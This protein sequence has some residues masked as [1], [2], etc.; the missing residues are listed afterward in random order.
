M[1]IIPTD[2]MFIN[3]N[4]IHQPRAHSKK[5]IKKILKYRFIKWVSSTHN[6][7]IRLDEIIYYYFC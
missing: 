7:Y 1:Q 4:P 2:K 3:K 5:K 6:M